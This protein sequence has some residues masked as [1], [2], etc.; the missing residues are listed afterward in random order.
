MY[1]GVSEGK[2]IFYSLNYAVW[3]D[4][5]LEPSPGSKSTFGGRELTT[6]P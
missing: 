1:G 2:D 3:T 5:T 6:S 4:T